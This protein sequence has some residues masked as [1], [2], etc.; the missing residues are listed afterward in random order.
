MKKLLL[1]AIAAVIGCAAFAQAP[2]PVATTKHLSEGAVLTMKLMQAV[3]SK[4]SQ[5]GDIL[6]FELAE[7][8]IMGDMVVLQKGLKATGH[9]TESKKAKGMGKQGT[10][11]IS[12]DYLTLSDGRVIKLTSQQDNEGK[13][14]TGAV[15]AG[16]VVLTPIFLFVKGKNINYEVGQVFKVYVAKDYEI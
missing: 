13:N 9:I 1:T 5:T 4:K 10:L 11:N 15:I 12:I 7:P 6:D 3:T 14:S 16:A 8:Y 2:A